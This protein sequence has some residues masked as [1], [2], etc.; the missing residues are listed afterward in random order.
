MCFTCTCVRFR[1][2]YTSAGSVLCEFSEWFSFEIIQINISRVR[3]CLCCG[4]V[5]IEFGLGL[6]SFYFVSLLFY[7]V[8]VSYFQFFFVEI[9][10]LLVVALVTIALAR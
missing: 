9:L 6:V 10:H 8:G 5:M 2:L 3:V 7:A 1:G 4:V